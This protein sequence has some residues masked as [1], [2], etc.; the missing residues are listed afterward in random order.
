MST[1]WCAPMAAIRHA[2]AVPIHVQGDVLVAFVFNRLG[3][4]FSDRDR[5]CLESIRP[6]LGH[7]YRLTRAV[8]GPQAAWGVPSPDPQ[9]DPR[10]T[11][12][13]RE[14]LEWL[15]GGKTDRDIAAILGIGPRTVHKHLQRIYEKLGVATRTAAVVRAMRQ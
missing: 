14:V 15:S 8:E 13:E 6:H 3:R 11:A 1:P 9:P 5:E 12:R 10:L 2:M 4:D 7:L